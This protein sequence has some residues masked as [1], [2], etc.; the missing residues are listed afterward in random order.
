MLSTMHVSRQQCH[1]LGM[2]IVAAA[3]YYVAGICACSARLLNFHGPD[4]LQHHR[5]GNYTVPQVSAFPKLQENILQGLR[6]MHQD[7]SRA[8]F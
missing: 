6:Q 7:A 2:K 4:R 1:S 8:S 5:A 3:V